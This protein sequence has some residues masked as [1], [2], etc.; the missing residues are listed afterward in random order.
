MPTSSTA[1][2]ATTRSSGTP[3][4]RLLPTDGRDVVNGGTE[5]AVGDTFVIN[6]NATSETYSIYTRGG[7]GCCRR[8]HL[9]SFNGRR[10]RSSSPAT[11]PSFANVIAELSEIEEIRINGVDPTGTTGGAGAGDTFNIIGDFSG[12][13]LRLNTI[14]IDG[15]AGDDTVDI[16]ALTSA[17]RIVFRSNG[18]NDTIIGDASG[19]RT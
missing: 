2:P 13:S 15:D 9:G 16:S 12:T 3:I 8:Q 17:H 18:G 19:R 5:G 6:G 7:L 1:T 10:P 4:T 11:A 14:T